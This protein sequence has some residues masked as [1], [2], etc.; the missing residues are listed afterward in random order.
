MLPATAMVI[1]V[2]GFSEELP[3]LDMSKY[4]EA[5]A[6]TAKYDETAEKE[7]KK[8]SPHLR[9]SAT[10]EASGRAVSPGSPAPGIGG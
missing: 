4:A 6:D 8:K 10:E 3:K 1:T 9:P 5:H 2:R 7:T